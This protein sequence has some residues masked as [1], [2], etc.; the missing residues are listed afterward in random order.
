MKTKKQPNLRGVAD[1][2]R[3]GG[4]VLKVQIG[5]GVSMVPGDVSALQAGS[6]A[7]SGYEA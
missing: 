2:S 5:A 4:V 3:A 7:R 6:S 1:V